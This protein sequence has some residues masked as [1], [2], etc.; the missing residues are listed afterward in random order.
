MLEFRRGQE[1]WIVSISNQFGSRPPVISIEAAAVTRIRDDVIY[2]G[3]GRRIEDDDMSVYDSEGSFIGHALLTR[4]AAE[5]LVAALPIW[6]T[7]VKSIAE[8]SRHHPPASSVNL[9]EVARLL[10]IDV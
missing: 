3:R 2:L 7:L 8:I 1:L 9:L 5:D 4:E 10:G 6:E